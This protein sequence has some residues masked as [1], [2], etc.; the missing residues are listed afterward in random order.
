MWIGALSGGHIF[1]I[2]NTAEWWT[3]MKK[4][5]WAWRCEALGTIDWASAWLQGHWPHL[6]TVLSSSYPHLFFSNSPFPLF[7]FS[8]HLFLPPSPLPFFSSFFPSSLLFFSPLPSPKFSSL[9]TPSTSHSLLFPSFPFLVQSLVWTI[10]LRLVL[11]TSSI[12]L[13]PSGVRLDSSILG[14]L[15]R[16]KESFQTE[17]HHPGP[18]LRPMSYQLLRDISSWCLVPLGVSWHLGQ[19]YKIFLTWNFPGIVKA[20]LRL[21]RSPSSS[22]PSV[23]IPRV[24]PQASYTYKHSLELLKESGTLSQGLGTSDPILFHSLRCA[25]WISHVTTEEG[26]Y[27]TWPQ[28]RLSSPAPCHVGLLGSTAWE[29]FTP[30]PE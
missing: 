21:L 15:R 13:K 24:L 16:G 11:A 5:E 23:L 3:A 4:E 8:L 10:S 30:R 28:E 7:I 2:H 29:L 27:Y 25:R 22:F 26:W 17:I 14:E 19:L 18:P 6:D 9:S 20:L 1:L 12:L